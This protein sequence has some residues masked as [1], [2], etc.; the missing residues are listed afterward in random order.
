[1]LAFIPIAPTAPIAI[2]AGPTNKPMIKFFRKIRYDLMEQNKTGKYLKY[3]FGEILLVVIGILIALQINN[4]NEA[5]K[6]RTK[7]VAYLKNIKVDLNLSILEIEDFIARRNAQIKAGNRVI[8]YYN[9]KPVANWNAYNKDIISIYAWERFFQIDNTFQELINSGNLAI[10][11]NDSIKNGLLNLD[12]FYKKLKYNEDHFRY[13]AEVTLYEPSYGMLDINSMANNFYYQLSD[14]KMGEKGDLKKEDFEAML[15]DQKQKNGFAFA[16]F[17]FTK[18]ITSFETIKKE[19]ETI[20]SLIDKDL[21][22]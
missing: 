9:G 14:G 16:V 5:R 18:M 6:T 3:A 7:E 1:L 11:S 15:K 21:A 2:G 22:D 10:I 17:E 20:I 8:E 4:L 13:D 12:V 19:C